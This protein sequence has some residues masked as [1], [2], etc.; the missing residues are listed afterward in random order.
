LQKQFSAGQ[1][2]SSILQTALPVDDIAATM[3]RPD[4]ANTSYPLISGSLNST[5]RVK[6][7]PSPNWMTSPAWFGDWARAPES[8]SKTI[9]QTRIAIGRPRRCMA[10]RLCLGWRPL[11]FGLLV[12]MIYSRQGHHCG[13]GVAC[14]Y[15]EPCRVRRIVRPLDRGYGTP[16]LVLTTSGK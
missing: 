13:F 16:L 8:T 14:P 3:L 4:R 2:S 10:K 11:A 6:V 9:V 5:Q 7:V 12:F 15:A 1:P